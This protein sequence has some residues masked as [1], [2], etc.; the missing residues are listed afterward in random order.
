MRKIFKR[1]AAFFVKA[2]ARKVYRKAV[3]IAE[4]RHSLE[5][6]TIYV[7]S[8]PF[9]QSKLVTCDR[10]DFREI[11]KALGI[12]K[13]P[14]EELKKGCWYHTSDAKGRGGMRPLDEKARAVAFERMMVKRAKL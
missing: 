3:D 5:K 4:K 2:Y 13:H 11:K 7:I 9:D 6:T 8:S 1:I 14:I 12:T 10:D